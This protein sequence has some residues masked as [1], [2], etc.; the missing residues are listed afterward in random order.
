MSV[1]LRTE[2]HLEFLTLKRG[3][4][5]L[6]KSALVEMP[7]CWKSR[8]TAHKVF[9]F[10]TVQIRRM[11]QLE[12][13]KDTLLQGLEV[14]ERLREWYHKQISLVT[15]KQNY[16]EKTSCSVGITITILLTDRSEQI[17]STRIIQDTYADL[18]D[19]PKLLEI[20]TFSCSTQLSMTFIMLINV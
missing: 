8:V 9:Y 20:Q 3:C 10:I 19:E 12:Q 2:H 5:G 11:K 13:E 6:S 4:T 7:H 1:K 18:S 14:T 16:V 15:E 17:V